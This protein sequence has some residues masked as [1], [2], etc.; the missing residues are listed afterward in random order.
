MINVEIAKYQ[1]EVQIWEYND[2]KPE[3]PRGLQVSSINISMGL[4]PS[5]PEEQDWFIFSISPHREIIDKTHKKRI[6]YGQTHTAFKLKLG[7][8]IPTV[9]L[10]FPLLHEAIGDFAKIYDERTK[11]TIIH[12]YKIEQPHIKEYR[13]NIQLTIDKW[14]KAIRGIY[15]N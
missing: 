11:N 5:M 3:L 1:I 6:F 2:D 9:E 4:T 8:T 10:L 13:E 14:I 12:H 15:H 7:K